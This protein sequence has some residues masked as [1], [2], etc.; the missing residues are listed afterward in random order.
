MDEGINI[1]HVRNTLF[2]SLP[3][4]PHHFISVDDVVWREKSSAEIDQ[5]QVG[6]R[7]MKGLRARVHFQSQSQV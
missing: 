6:N 5:F 7:R 1:D 3:D 2:D 4:K